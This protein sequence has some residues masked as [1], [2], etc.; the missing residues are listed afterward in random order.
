MSSLYTFEIEA[1][2][3][4]YDF[5]SQRQVGVVHSVECSLVYLVLAKYFRSRFHRDT[6]WIDRMSS[7]IGVIYKWAAR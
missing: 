3:N 5:F 2:K 4:T 6:C 7:W 1:S